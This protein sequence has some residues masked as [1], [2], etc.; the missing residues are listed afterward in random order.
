MS[1]LVYISSLIMPLIVLAVILYGLLQ[2]V[3]IYGAFVIGAKEGLGTV[4]GILP[5]LIGLLCAVTV[6][7]ESGAL[8]MLSRMLAPLANGLGIPSEVIPLGLMKMFS[9]SG[10]T[11][12]LTDIFK[13]SGPDSFSGRVASVML[14]STETIVYTMS[15]YFVG[16]GIKN[17]K[18]TLKGAIIANLAGMIGAYLVVIWFFY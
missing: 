9:S 16:I 7:R 1:I 13:T 6:L 5:T 15:V 10:A 8:D 3:D 2:S 18:H 14:C 11:G 4:V 12:L 17:T